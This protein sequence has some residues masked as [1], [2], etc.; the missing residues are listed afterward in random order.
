MKKQH[1]IL[2]GIVLAGVCLLLLLRMN[3]PDATTR[4]RLPGFALAP[5]DYGWSG[6]FPGEARHIFGKEVRVQIDTRAVPD[7]P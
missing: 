5:G 7:E 1:I 2:A 3:R 6:S 4:Q